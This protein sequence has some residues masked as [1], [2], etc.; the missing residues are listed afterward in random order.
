MLNFSSG[1]SSFSRIKAD[2]YR[3]VRTHALMDAHDL[4]F[5]LISKA[6]SLSHVLSI[7]IINCVDFSSDLDRAS[8]RGRLPSVGSY[9]KFSQAYSASSSSD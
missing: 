6:A 7:Q 4:L 1:L 9:G 8:L 2:R 5:E 3:V